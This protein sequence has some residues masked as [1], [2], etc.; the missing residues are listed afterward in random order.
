M[1]PEYVTSLFIAGALLLGFTV[2]PSPAQEPEVIAGGE[3]E[4][5]RHCASCHGPDGKG[6]GVLATQLRTQPA[7][8]TR[9]RSY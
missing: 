6:N 5:Q 1:L 3:I 4:Y 8:L 7:D 9:L 2:V